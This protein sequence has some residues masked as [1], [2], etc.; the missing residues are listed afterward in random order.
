M[1][2]KEKTKGSKSP[3]AIGD[4]VQHMVNLS[5]SMKILYELKSSLRGFQTQDKWKNKQL[6]FCTLASKEQPKFKKTIPFT[7]ASKNL[8]KNKFTDELYTLETIKQC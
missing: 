4:I 2:E 5:K 6:H 1:G 7:I 3:L 8:L